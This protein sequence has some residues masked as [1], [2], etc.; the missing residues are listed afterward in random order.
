MTAA[1]LTPDEIASWK[2]TVL[3]EP[4][5]SDDEVKRLLATIDHL[6]AQLAERDARIA[7]LENL[8]S[9]VE[10]WASE[11]LRGRARIAELEGRIAN[12]LL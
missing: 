12:A 9:D 5:W 1:P 7:E 4:R 8:V 6:T 10:E 2:M 11:A 3:I